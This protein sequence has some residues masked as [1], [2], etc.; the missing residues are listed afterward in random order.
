MKTGIAILSIA[1]L[2]YL[3]GLFLPWW[4]IAIVAFLIVF[5]LKLK[6]FAAFLAGFAAIF[7]LWLFLSY[8]LSS[9]NGHVLATKMSGVI[10]QLENPFLLMFVTG[11]TGGVVAG[12]GAL[13]GSY[14]VRNRAGNNT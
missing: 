13:S 9:T 2:S 8:F 1:G 3:A 14:L 11:L 12:L 10:L 7:L 4:S 5:V 6:P